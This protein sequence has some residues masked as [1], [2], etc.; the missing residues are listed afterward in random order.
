MGA[1]SK[2]IPITHSTFLNPALTLSRIPPFAGFIS[3]DSIL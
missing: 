1:L 3:N 2:K